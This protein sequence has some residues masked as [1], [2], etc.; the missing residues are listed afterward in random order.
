MI[1]S[2]Q[3]AQ[4][5]AKFVFFVHHIGTPGFRTLHFFD[6]LLREKQIL[7]TLFQCTAREAENFG[8]FLNDSLKELRRW[9]LDKTVY[10]KM[11]HGAKKD[12]PGCASKLNPDQTPKLLLDYED[13]RRLLYKWHRQLH[14]AVKECLTSGEYMHIRNAIILIK[15][16]HKQWPEVNYQGEQTVAA[17][18]D[19]SKNDPRDDLKLSAQSLMGDL[20]KRKKSWVPTQAFMRMVSF[21]HIS[22]RSLFNFEQPSDMAQAKGPSRSTS[23]RPITP[24]PGAKAPRHLDPKVP[25]FKSVRET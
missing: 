4:F 10:D 8:R 16:V 2:P 22:R 5:T 1:L 15:A 24:Q 20:V 19:L 11:A 21:S 7:A 12:L 9:S 6:Q 17:I 14:G 13:F 18:T 23:A 25:E 3:D